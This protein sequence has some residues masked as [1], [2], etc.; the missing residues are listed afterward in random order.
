MHTTLKIIQL[1][2][3][4]L[5]VLSILVQNRSSGLSGAISG[6]AGAVQSTKRG[7][8]KVVFNATVVL[9]VLFVGLS[10]AFIFVP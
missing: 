7:A 4:I 2:V 9:A 10:L 5:M 8:E 6:Q 3:S 1:I